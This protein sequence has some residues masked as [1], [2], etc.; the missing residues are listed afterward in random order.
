VLGAARS[1]PDWTQ[2]DHFLA[3]NVT[4]AVSCQQVIDAVKDRLGGIDIIV[5]VVRGS[6]A[7]WWWFHGPA[8]QRLFFCR[9]S[10]DCSP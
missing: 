7:P 5:H 6:S 8:L 10:I 4:G 3:A 1:C 9:A 2:E